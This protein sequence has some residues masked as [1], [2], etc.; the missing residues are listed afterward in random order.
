MILI[1]R[2]VVLGELVIGKDPDCSRGGEYCNAPVIKRKINYTTDIIVHEAYDKEDGYKHDIALIRINDPVPLFQE[3]PEISSANPIC[4]PWSED[5]YAHYI[6]DGD[7]PTVVGWKRS[8]GKVKYLRST[9]APIANEKCKVAK[10]WNI[11]TTRQI[12]AGDQ[13]GE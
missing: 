12:C 8:V 11:D 1:C 3:D 2:E 13:K 7:N 5:S 10:E 4:L 9:R 6:E